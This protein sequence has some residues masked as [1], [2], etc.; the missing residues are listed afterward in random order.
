MSQEKVEIR[1]NIK[2]QP[3]IGTRSTVIN[4]TSHGGGSIMPGGGSRS[5][6]MRMSMG[7]SAPSFAQGT[8]SSMS[9]KNVANVLDTRA[10]EKTE[11]N[12]LNERFASYI[13]KVRFVEA[14]NKALLAEIDRLKKQ[15]N[16]DASEIKELYEQEI[17]DSRKIIDDLSDEKAK[18]D[19]TLVSLQDQLEDERRDRINAEKTVDD[20]SNKIDRLNDQ[21]GNNEGEL[22]NLRLRIET[23]EDENARLKKDKRTLQDDIGRIRADLDEETCKRIQAEMKLQ[24]AEEDCKFQINIYEAEIAELKAML[25]RDR[26]IEMKDI[27]KGEIS[28]AINELNTQYASEVDRIQAEMQKNY[29]MQM[30]EMRAGLN[31]DNMETM[32]AREESKKVKGKLNELQPLIS[33]LQAENAMLKSRLE[34]LQV[35]YDD[36]CREHESDVNKLQ[37]SIERLQMEMDSVLTEL[38]VLQD[39]KLSLELEIA[40]YRKLLEAE[41]TN[42]R[43][44]VEHSSGSRSGGAQLLSDMIVSKGGSGDS[45]KSTLSESSNKILVQ[46]TCRGDI[47]IENAQP[48]GSCVTLKNSSKKDIVSVSLKGWSLKKTVNGVN[49]HTY[50]FSD[51]SLLKGKEIKLFSKGAAELAKD[52][53]IVCDIFSWGLSGTFTLNDDKGVE[54]ATLTIKTAS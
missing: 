47:S 53:D 27:W 45:Q 16:F 19:A 4:R 23:L 29:E 17:A 20:L 15:K 40:A 21:L 28:K 26:S 49:K 10:K 6:S 8:V 37:A 5:V 42:M 9:H 50:T 33:Q 13:E 14:Q 2:T 44:V 25:D 24:T 7:G 18:F 38:Q 48:D 31:R 22:A 39:A 43:R 54:K 46:R 36:E 52:S 12:V 32:S 41:E 51:I 3:T 35:Q 11:M 1:R 34:G 30:N